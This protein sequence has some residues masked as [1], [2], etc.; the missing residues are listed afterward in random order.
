MGILDEIEGQAGGTANLFAREQNIHRE[1][2]AMTRIKKGYRKLLITSSI[3]IF[4]P[5]VGTVIS[6]FCWLYYVRVSQTLNRR[7]AISEAVTAAGAYFLIIVFLLF[8]FDLVDWNGGGEG[9]LWWSVGS[10]FFFTVFLA[11]HY[12]EHVVAA[13]KTAR[14]ASDFMKSQQQ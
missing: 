12:H 5:I 6:C 8:A 9:L 14:R 13:E 3:S 1:A 7:A 11:H 2:N 10:S 4:I